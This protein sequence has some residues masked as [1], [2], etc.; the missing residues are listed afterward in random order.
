M[1]AVVLRVLA[2]TSGNGPA[3][4]TGRFARTV[5]LTSRG[6]R[7]HRLLLDVVLD[8]AHEVL[9]DAGVNPLETD[10]DLAEH[11]ADRIVDDEPDEREGPVGHPSRDA[12]DHRLRQHRRAPEVVPTIGV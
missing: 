12:A 4:A 9:A 11:A 1:T 10:A 6:G 3:R 2:A 5:R 7:R 8:A